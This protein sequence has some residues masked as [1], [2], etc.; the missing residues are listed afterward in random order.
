MARAARGRLNLRVSRSTGS[1]TGGTSCS[2]RPFGVARGDSMMRSLSH[3][4]AG[5]GRARAGQC[6]SSRRASLAASRGQSSSWYTLRPAFGSVRRPRPITRPFGVRIATR[7]DS[8]P[9]WSSRTSFVLGRGT[10][11][12]RSTSMRAGNARSGCRALR[13][14][15]V[16]APIQVFAHP[17]HKPRPR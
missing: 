3:E 13:G 2:R 1:T 6:R 14:L 4:L 5:G 11:R 15:F 9:H 8:R 17:R 10:K 16:R 12:L 7:N